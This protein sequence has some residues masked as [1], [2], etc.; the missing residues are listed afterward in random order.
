MSTI[1]TLEELKAAEIELHLSATD[2]NAFSIMGACS[3][4]ARKA[5]ASKAL[6]NEMRCELTSMHSYDDILVWVG[7]HF[8]VY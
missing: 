8:D 4:A 6:R 7:S 5:G 3:K 2:G 1:E